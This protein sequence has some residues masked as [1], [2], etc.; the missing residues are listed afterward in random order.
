MSPFRK[1][2][3]RQLWASPLFSAGSATFEDPSGATFE[4]VVVHHP[5]AV[6][7]VPVTDGGDVLLVRQYRPPV[8]RELLEIPA[9]LRDV[10]GEDAATTARRELAEEVGMTAG[11]LRELARFFH[12]PG[13]C[14]EES[15]VFLAQ[16]LSP[17]PT[18]ARSIEEHHMVVEAVALAEVGALVASGAIVDAKSIIGL[19]LAGA[20]LAR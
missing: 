19:L 16:D 3:E 4:R 20:L 12:S 2:A 17:C 9:G 10:A 14:D 15:V 6:S 13:F 1:L 8:D 7:V 18:D 5:G 11:R